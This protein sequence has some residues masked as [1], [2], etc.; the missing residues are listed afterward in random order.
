MRKIILSL[1]YLILVFQKVYA[2]PISTDILNIEPNTTIFSFTWTISS[3]TDGD[4]IKV[5]TWSNIDN[6]FKVR[7]LWFDTPEKY[8]FNIVD[9]KY[10]GC[11]LAASHFA[12][13]NIEIWKEYTFY[14]DS[15]AKI[16]DDY[17]RQLRFL[18]LS[19]WSLTSSWTY[20][21]SI[22]NEWLANYY[23]YEN[24]SFTWV[25]EEI[26]NNNK[27]LQKWMYNPFCKAQ[28]IYIKENHSRVWWW[29]IQTIID[30]TLKEKEDF[31]YQLQNANFDELITLENT[32]IF[33]EKDDIN[34]TPTQIWE[35]K[36]NWNILIAYISIWEAE[37]RRDY[38]NNSW[39]DS[40]WNLTDLAPSWLGEKNPNWSSYKVKF[41]E[42]WWKEIVYSRINDIKE[43]W[44]DWILLDVVD[45]YDYWQNQVSDDLKVVDADDKMITF[46]SDIRDYL[47]E[48]LAIIPN[49]WFSLIEKP[50]YL[51]LINWFLTE[52]IFSENSIERPDSE[53][54][55]QLQYLEQIQNYWSWKTIMDIDYIS[56]NNDLVC[57]YYDYINE[58]WFLWADYNLWLN[59]FDKIQCLYEKNLAKEY[60][61][62]TQGTD[63]SYTYYSPAENVVDNNID[64]YNHTSAEDDENWLQV[65]IPWLIWV[66]K[67]S[68]LSRQDYPSRLNNSKVY[69]LEQSYTW[70][71]DDTKLVAT[72]KWITDKQEFIF[73]PT[74]KGQ[75]ILIKAAEWQN[76]HIA[77]LEVFWYSKQEPDFNNYETDF[78][79]PWNTKT[80]SIISTVNAIDYQNDSLTY[81]LSWAIDYFDID[82]N[83]NIVVNKTLDDNTNYKLQIIVSDWINQI[84]SDLINIK[85]SSISAI[86]DA[87]KLW[88]TDNITEE[89]LIQ[90][91][92]DEIWDEQSTNQTVVRDIFLHFKNK[93]FYFD[94]DKCESDDNC[95]DAT[96]SWTTLTFSDIRWQFSFIRA[97]YSDFH[98]YDKIDIFKQDWYKLDKLIIL[99]ADKFRKSVLFPMDKYKTDD[100]DF[101][102]SYFSDYIINN[103]RD[104][105]PAQKNMWNFS[106][107]DFSSIPLIT[108]EIDY[109]SKKP[110]KAA[111]IYAIPGQTF[112]IT[113]LD[114][115]DL[116]VRIFIN[117]LRSGATHEFRKDWYNRPKNLQ[118]IHIKILSWETIK[119]TSPYWW[120]IQVE[121]SEANLPVKLKF[122]NVA[123]H[124]YRNWPEDSISFTE[125]LNEW[126]FNWAEIST[127]W[128]EV[129]SRLDLMKKT[130]NNWWTVENVANNTIKYTSNYPL[131]LAW[132]KWPWI[133]TSDEIISFATE[134]NLEIF[135][136]DSIKHFNA[137]QALCGYGCSWNPYD[138][139]WAFSIVWHWDI[140]EI[141]HW[142]EKSIFMPSW[143]SYHA[144]T[145]PYSYFTQ[146]QYN[147]QSWKII[148]SQNLPFLDV[149]NKM[150]ES[151]DLDNYFEIINNYIWDWTSRDKEILFQ[152]QAMMHAQKMWKLNDWWYLIS[153]LH[154][155]ERNRTNIKN[156][157][158]NRK[159]DIWFSNYS[160]DEFNNISNNDWDLISYS[161]AAL[162]D[163]RDYFD[164]WWINYSQKASEQ[165]ESFNYPKVAKTFFM[166]TPHW[167]TQIDEY[168]E[169]LAKKEYNL[170]WNEIIN[171]TLI[172]DDITNTWT[173]D[174][175]INP[176]IKIVYNIWWWGWWWL[177]K[178][179]CPNWD[180]SSSYYDKKCNSDIEKE[181]KKNIDK[182][183]DEIEPKIKI[184]SKNKL[185]KNII[186]A[187]FNLEKNVQWKNT[188]KK[189]ENSIES[190][191]KDEL[192]EKYIELNNNI[193]KT[194]K[195]NYI[196][197]YT[198]SKI[199]LQLY[200]NN[201]LDNKKYNIINQSLD[202]KVTIVNE[203]FIIEQNNKQTIKR[204]NI[205]IKHLIISKYELEKKNEWINFIKNINNIIDK[206]SNE[207]LFE[208]YNKITSFNSNIKLNYLKSIIWIELYNRDL[209]K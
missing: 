122:E 36:S 199:W 32:I 19:T 10:Y 88:I 197:K 109:T 52:S 42:D 56:D 160:L 172:I 93:D 57:A 91:V 100:N 12:E 208:I 15:L 50:W 196:Y 66:T 143:A 86:D 37:T 167:Y 38:W 153:R 82:N 132:Y 124:P 44:Y 142:L 205:L 2:N 96:L 94:W 128:F 108:K 117:S 200:K 35:L 46:I 130:I 152:I 107:S 103:Y 98:D 169:Y 145:N 112:K 90:A 165:V 163:Y 11:W 102:K 183:I 63:S 135:Y 4:T 155:L 74:K 189:I 67:I 141:W 147:K 104:I 41:W 151:V 184:Y 115:S 92:I 84:I 17:W 69:I 119:F 174:E 148:D 201:L 191:N 61:I 31:H 180:F 55:W 166:S 105:N 16:E 54:N 72:L 48:Y 68:I 168:W 137:D 114:N 207:K 150:K 161:Y 14:S 133:D 140:H 24:H 159:Q 121:F 156:D 113:R 26:D 158:E 60:G 186:I 149:F 58:K 126:I 118:S 43:V 64:T 9:Y 53:K 111:W 22:L 62:F 25:Y 154:L 177:T 21:Y 65:Y 13:K 30:K 120:P 101:M 127:S 129:H 33:L 187:K 80:G 176:E 6:D 182:Q 178:D 157:W 206:L 71:I 198:I 59:S 28:D 125:K 188:I 95:D 164:M 170:K 3:I 136:T 97:L 27:I 190:L 1:I 29:E 76:L 81:T 70:T 123:E 85:T 78:L 47:W 110:F 139:Y 193:N 131:L 18:Q 45:V 194:E 51:D 209:V 179:N 171:D 77:E 75:Y 34:L 185:I 144:T 83:W 146:T 23:Q 49:Q 87:I 192:I 99:T 138:A 173:T 79:I 8:L 20:W 134:N 39:I 73:S 203:S 175:V 7:L 162:L 106:E 202:E 40:E 5:Y 89:E 204:K 116:D 195:E 181:K